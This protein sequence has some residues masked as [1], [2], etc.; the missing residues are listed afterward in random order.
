M[1]KIYLLLL[2]GLMV[3][4]VNAQSK[5]EKKVASAVE[6]LTAAME[7]GVRSDLEDITANELSYGHSSGNIEN[8][9]TFVES[10]ASGKSDFVSIDLTEQTISLSGKTALV[11][12]KLSAKTNDNGK[13]GTVRL[14]V[15]LVFQKQHGHWKLLA[16]QA[17]KI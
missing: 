11:R 8:K 7:S 9:A 14:G 3:T 12:H 13:P 17:Y 15:L 2:C 4:G 10:I 16:R 6:T 5:A 1:K